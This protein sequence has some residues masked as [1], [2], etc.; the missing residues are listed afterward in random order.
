MQT[1][2]AAAVGAV[3]SLRARHD[4]DRGVFLLPSVDGSTEV[5][6]GQQTGAAGDGS[7]AAGGDAGS[8]GAAPAA[9]T[10]ALG[11]APSGE[12]GAAGEAKTGE[13]GDKVKEGEG[14]KAPVVPEAYEFKLP[15][16][17]TL[18][19]ARAEEFSTVAKS[20]KLT[21]EQAQQL[22]DLDVKRAQDQ[23]AAHAETVKGWANDLKADKDYGGDN[24]PATLADC[25]KVMDTFATPEL[26]AYLDSTGLGNYP[27]LVRFVAKIGKSLSEDTFVKGGATTTAKDPAQ[28]MYP[29][30]NM[31]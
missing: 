2:I 30:S 16:G 13:Q 29:N 11:G 14:A 9:G 20:L 19:T 25:R 15:E 26:R 27:G 5:A 24:L 1:T 3:L 22:V 7:T 8:T 21:Q 10:T 4:A 12:A 6:G 28:A 23:M 18:D 17:V 31:N